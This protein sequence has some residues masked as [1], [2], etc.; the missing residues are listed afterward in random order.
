[1]N[2]VPSPTLRQPPAGF[3]LLSTGQTVQARDISRSPITDAWSSVNDE[4]V[5]HVVSGINARDNIFARKAL[6]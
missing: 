3:K 1:M 4:T 5:G 2:N 6:R